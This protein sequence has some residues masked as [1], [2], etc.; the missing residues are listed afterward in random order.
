MD[1]KQ[2]SV[3]AN[4]RRKLVDQKHRHH[5]HFK[6]LINFEA[7][8]EFSYDD[9][10][11]NKNRS[12]KQNKSF[13]KGFSQSNN[14]FKKG[15]KKKKSKKSK[16]A[17][18]VMNAMSKWKGTDYLMLINNAENVNNLAV[19]HQVVKFSSYFTLKEIQQQWHALLYDPVVSF[20]ARKMINELSDDV[21]KTYNDKTLF[22]DD[23]EDI[24]KTISSISLYTLENFQMLLDNHSDIFHLSRSARNLMDH[25]QL[26]KYHGLLCDQN[27]NSSIDFPDNGKSIKSY[28]ICK[29]STFSDQFSL[30]QQQFVKDLQNNEND[31]SKVIIKNA[32]LI[33]EETG[34]DV[35]ATLLG[36][37]VCYLLKNV[38]VTFGR[39]TFDESVD[40]DLSIEGPAFKVSRKQGTI[41]KL[42]D[43]LF[44][45]INEGKQVVY[46]DGK[47]VLRGL[48]SNICHSSIIEISNLRFVFFIN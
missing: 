48:K 2:Y 40:I 7:N 13:Q 18:S 36:R 24:L 14:L 12:E 1:I 31:E 45:L 17:N 22:S 8:P 23:E 27:S 16:S 41:K 42:S 19:I 39:S 47:P 3:K 32:G 5:I 30:S 9:K 10:Q 44:V 11:K 38:E 46:V 15:I 6:Q 37:F 21:R 25:W 33:Y 26:M 35:V 4:K 34:D 20:H 28:N 43:G 29:K